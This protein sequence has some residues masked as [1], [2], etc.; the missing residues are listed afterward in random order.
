MKHSAVATEKQSVA[1]EA[2]VEFEQSQLS[3]NVIQ[4][5][6]LSVITA[7]QLISAGIVNRLP[8]ATLSPLRIAVWKY[9][10]HL[11][12]LPIVGQSAR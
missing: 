8:D 1:F 4:L 2:I 9:Q 11:S 6:G 3:H 7:R 5:D 12:S 10:R